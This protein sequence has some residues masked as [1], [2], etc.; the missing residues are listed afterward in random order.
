MYAIIG[1][2]GLAKLSALEEKGLEVANRFWSYQNHRMG[3]GLEILPIAGNESQEWMPLGHVM[4]TSFDDSNDPTGEHRQIK[5]L[6]WEA[7]S[8]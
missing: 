8:E 6:L 4:L 2:S 1:G 5:S 7:R 3:R